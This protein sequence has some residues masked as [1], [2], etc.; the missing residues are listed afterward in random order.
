LAGLPGAVVPLW[1]V[2][3]L[4]AVTP[5]WLKVA[6]NQAGVLWQVSQL[7]VVAT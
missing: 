3:Q 5:L 2:L 1:Q 7:C 6:G 4:P